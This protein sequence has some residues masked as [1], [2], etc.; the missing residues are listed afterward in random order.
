MSKAR[1]IYVVSYVDDI[2]VTCSNIKKAYAVYKHFKHDE[3][4]SSYRV[5]CDRLCFDGKFVHDE[6]DEC[7]TYQSDCLVIRVTTLNYYAGVKI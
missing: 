5:V 3:K 4:M 6:E 7:I 1:R 2:L